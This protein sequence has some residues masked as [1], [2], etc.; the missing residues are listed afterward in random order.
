MLHKPGYEGR[1]P[2]L[3]PTHMH[4]TED[5]PERLAPA[6]QSNAAIARTLAGKIV[7]PAITS[8]NGGNGNG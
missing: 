7:R 3:V 4:S 2:P 8:G 5:E 1:K 6:V